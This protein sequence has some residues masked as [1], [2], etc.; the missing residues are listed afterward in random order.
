MYIHYFR[1]NPELLDNYKYFWIIENDVYYPKSLKNF[2]D[3]HD[4]FENDLFVSEYGVRSN[5]WKR[6]KSLKG[7][8]HIYNIGILAVIMRLSSKLIKILILTIDKKFNGYLETLLPHL[9]IHHNLVIQQF[10]PEL[11][12]ILTTDNKNSFLK[13][14]EYDILNN[15]NTFLENKIYHPIKL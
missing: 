9:C 11:C 3:Q 7:F 15:K 5:K 12:G 1:N 2:I 10:L 6:V 8:L 14:I 4:M 13:L